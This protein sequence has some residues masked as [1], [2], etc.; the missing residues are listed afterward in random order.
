MKVGTAGWA[1]PGTTD[2]NGDGRG[3]RLYYWSGDNPT[4]N[5]MQWHDLNNWADFPDITEA[6]LRD[7]LWI[8]DLG[9]GVVCGAATTATRQNHGVLFTTT[10]AVTWTRMWTNEPGD[11]AEYV[12][13]RMFWN[14]DRAELVL[15]ANAG[16]N[17]GGR[18]G[19]TQTVGTTIQAPQLT[20]A[21]TSG[22]DAFGPGQPVDQSDM[23]A[24]GIVAS[25]D[26]TAATMIIKASTGTWGPVNTG[27]RVLGPQETYSPAYAH[28][29]ADGN[30]DQIQQFDPGFREMNGNPPYSINFPATLNDGSVPDDELPAGT[31]IQVEIQAESSASGFTSVTERWS[32]TV[33][34]T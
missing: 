4:D 27:L 9:I 6:D 12:W 3:R 7:S 18:V 2:N 25:L 31:R 20:F 29:D 21:S 15:V 1:F 23:N 28:I 17:P 14:S 32:N 22:L 30:V 5:C 33:T 11:N 26:E 19:Y 24:A 13:E 10:D 16:T 34:P 8:E